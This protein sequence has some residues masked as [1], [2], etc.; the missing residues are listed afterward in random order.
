VEKTDKRTDKERNE[1]I[2]RNLEP[3]N[4][5][6]FLMLARAI[7][8]QTDKYMGSSH[9]RNFI[10]ELAKQLTDPLT[11]D[12]LNEILTGLNVILND[13]LKAS[14]VVSKGKAKKAKKKLNVTKGSEA[15]LEEEE[16]DYDEYDEM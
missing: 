14:K 7:A 4:D 8:T 1:D 6:D 15:N 5:A 16:N 12:D 10:K 2:L 3:K 9:Y 13:K 11:T